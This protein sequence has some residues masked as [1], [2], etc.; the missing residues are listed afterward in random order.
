MARKNRFPLEMGNGV[1]VNNINELRQN[2]D[3]GAVV[4]YFQNGQLVEW[5]DARYY[6]KI[7]AVKAIPA[8]APDLRQQLCAALGVSYT[9]DPF[10]DYDETTL[11]PEQKQRLEAKK[12]ILRDLTD[13]NQVIGHALQTA[14]TQD[15]LYD[16]WD[17]Q[18]PTIYLLGGREFEIS[19]RV[20]DTHYVGA[21]VEELGEPTVKIDAQKPEECAAKN[22]TFAQVILPWGK[23]APQP[24]QPAQAV[25]SA[26]SGSDENVMEE[27]RELYKEVFVDNPATKP[28]GLVAAHKLLMKYKSEQEGTSHQDNAWEMTDGILQDACA[29]NQHQK[30]TALR[31]VCQ[32]L[33]TMDEIVHLKVSNDFR[34][35]WALTKDSLCLATNQGNYVFKYNDITEVDY[36]PDEDDAY[37]RIFAIHT[38]NDSF[39]TADTTDEDD[40][41]E[42]GDGHNYT[43]FSVDAIALKL[44]VEQAKDIV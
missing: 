26:S 18:L 6:D 34:Y 2:F 37:D 22:I 24:V 20:S 5:L 1:K 19:L 11:D 15:D 33:Y 8:D 23:A 14:I 30:K 3:L 13:D 35:G 36:T 9:A 17:M 4:Q 31:K 12:N 43:Y 38:A 42:D 25:A 29:M 40:E 41:D 28:R 39:S 27:L 16:L 7:E 10:S 32:N 21:F 44:F